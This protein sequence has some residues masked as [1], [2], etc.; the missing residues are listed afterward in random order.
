MNNEKSTNPNVA[1]I[2]EYAE[3]VP[4]NRLIMEN[5][6]RP[7]NATNNATNVQMPSFIP[8]AS[9][10][11]P[12]IN[13][14]TNIDNVAKTADFMIAGSVNARKNENMYPVSAENNE[15]TNILRYMFIGTMAKIKINTN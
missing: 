5:I 9:K 7:V 13:M 15:N 14:V 8:K 4:I 10:V 12:A 2:L 3:Y 6:I 1:N 11:P